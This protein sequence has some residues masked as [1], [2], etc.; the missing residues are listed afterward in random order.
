MNKKTLLIL[1][2]IL[3]T[4]TGCNNSSSTLTSENAPF[5]SEI[6][7]QSNVFESAI[8]IT[9]KDKINEDIYLNFIKKKHYY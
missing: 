6:Y 4:L 7:V 8:E 3:F 5:I 2:F 1:P 9:N